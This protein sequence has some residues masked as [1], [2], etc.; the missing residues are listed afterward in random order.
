MIDNINKKCYTVKIIL[1]FKRRCIKMLEQPRLVAMR[2][3]E[4]RDIAGYSVEETAE[5][6]N[7]KAEQYAQYEQDGT[8]IPISVVYAL[9]HIYKSDTTEILTGKSPKKILL[10]LVKK[11]Q[12]L[13]VERF[14]GYNYENIAHQYKN[15]TME[16]MIVTLDPGGEA[17]KM[18]MHSGQEINY[19]L[20]GRMTLYHDG[21]EIILEEGDCAYFD[22][23]KPHG[24]CAAGDAPAKF[25]TV[26][27]E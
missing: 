13:K 16:P 7:I 15:K 22:P 5:K 20:E 8:D 25:L 18:V 21:N 19:C 23:T 9:A 24:Q 3:R 1:K 12:G 17:P 27:N 4:L 14:E 2:I 11:G 10:S 6:L 26:I